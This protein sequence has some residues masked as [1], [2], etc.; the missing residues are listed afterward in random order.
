MG[1]YKHRNKEVEFYKT[2][3]VVLSQNKYSETHVSSTDGYVTSSGRVVSPKIHSNSVTKHELW[4][5][6]ADGR[7]ISV[8]LSG[9]NIALREGQ[10]ITLLS[11]GR[12]DLNTNYYVS[13]INHSSGES[14]QINTTKELNNLLKLEPITGWS[15]WKAVGLGGVLVFLLPAVMG[16]SQKNTAIAIAVIIAFLYFA[17][18]I[19][20]RL[21]RRST[22]LK[23]LQEY[24]S[25]LLTNIVQ[26]V[27]AGDLSNGNV[28][29][30]GLYEEVEAEPTK[31]LEAT[32][33]TK[34]ETTPEPVRKEKKPS[35]KKKGLAQLL[36]FLPAPLLG[37]HRFYLRDHLK[38]IFLLIS[39]PLIMFF[40]T[41]YTRSLGEEEHILFMKNTLNPFGLFTPDML[42]DI[43]TLAFTF[44]MF[45]ILTP[46][47]L[48]SLY[49]ILRLTLMSQEK[50]KVKYNPTLDVSDDAKS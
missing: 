7:E 25:Q 31:L 9:V 46:A 30:R 45:I 16:H 20:I 5:K 42:S 48:I 8:Q 2:T 22:V 32:P 12:T 18:R 15:F 17:Y 27:K 13:L 43:N 19:I 11:A 39:I 41:L 38:G 23:S 36:M 26:H 4:I 6:T 37:L 28:D 3:G 47:I 49:E 24:R 29:V 35:I 1:N 10:V 33:E 21:T 40:T 50:F 14:S 44:G 34:V